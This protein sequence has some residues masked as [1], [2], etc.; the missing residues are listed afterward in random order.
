MDLLQTYVDQLPHHVLS[1]KLYGAVAICL[2]LEGVFFVH[3]RPL[4]HSTD[5]RHHDRNFAGR[6]VVW[7]RLFGTWHPDRDCYPETGL[8][9]PAYPIE[10]SGRP[11]ALLGQTVP[12]Y[13][14]P[15]RAIARER[16][17]LLRLARSRP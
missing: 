9:D 16:P 14:H 2:A 4:H 10:T 3:V 1:W 5:P 7:D 12:Q 6:F 17:A 15:F 13:L 11:M 8:D